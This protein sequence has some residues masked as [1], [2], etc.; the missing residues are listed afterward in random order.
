LVSGVLRQRGPR[1]A[2]LVGFGLLGLLASHRRL[3][4]IADAGYVAPP[5]LFA[6][7]CAAALLRTLAGLEKQRVLRVRLQAI[8]N[9]G[10]TLIVGLAFLSRSIQ[11]A[12]DERV[13]VPG[14][15]G[16]LSA[17]PDT[18]RDLTEVAAVVRAETGEKNGV[19]VVPEGGVINYL[20]GRPNP[21]RHKISIPGYLRESNEDDFLGDLRRARPE[22]IVFIKRP[23]GEYGRGS[24]GEGY[25]QRTRDWIEKH[26]VR[27]PVAAV[28]AEVYTITGRPGF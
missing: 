7:V 20:A 8:L 17:L 1:A 27:R 18:A 6:F 15:D 13:P 23:A 3:F 10:L 22:T 19:V 16:M 2:A 24:F 4:H 9:G 5:L 26:Y 12:A 11:Y 28:V 14:T 25:G 21:M